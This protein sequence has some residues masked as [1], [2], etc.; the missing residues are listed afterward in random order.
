MNKYQKER[1]R[2]IRDIMRSDGFGRMTYKEARRK[3]RAGIRAFR[4]GDMYAWKAVD[5][6]RFRFSREKLKE[7]GRAYYKILM[8]CAERGL[9]FTCDYKSYY[10]YYLLSFKGKSFDDMRY[11]VDH[12]VTVDLIQCATSLVDLTDYIL[13]KVNA[14]LREFTLPS[15]VKFE[16]GSDVLK[17]NPDILYP[18]MTLHPWDCRLV[19]PVLG[20]IIVK[21]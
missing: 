20:K 15:V 10:D 12:S 14:E 9:T 7:V 4:I 6:G 3:W 17:Y 13:E 2:E 18:R 8:Y 11:R 1:S 21:E 19:E 5:L 16:T